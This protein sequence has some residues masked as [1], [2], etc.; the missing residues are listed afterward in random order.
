MVGSACVVSGNKSNE[1]TKIKQMRR[2]VVGT[3]LE[4][5]LGNAPR[6]S[7]RRVVGIAYR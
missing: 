6:Q 1:K 7:L 4:A 2:R 5:S 3:S